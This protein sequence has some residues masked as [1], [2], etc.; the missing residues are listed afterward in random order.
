MLSGKC[1]VAFIPSTFLHRTQV[2]CNTKVKG[3][4]FAMC[5]PSPSF[6]KGTSYL[7]SL[8]L[9]CQEVYV[10]RYGSVFKVPI[11][12]PGAAHCHQ[13]G[14][15]QIQVPLHRALEGF[16]LGRQS[17]RQ[18]VQGQMYPPTSLM[19][20]TSRCTAGVYCPGPVL[21]RPSGRCPGMVQ[22]QAGRGPSSIDRR[23]AGGYSEVGGCL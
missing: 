9:V 23:R 7:L 3:I 1:E 10:F 15:S 16:Q 4:K 20:L 14:P 12:A 19:W 13:D 22:T 18:G 5:L 8:N 21:A 11:G 17:S 6:V 2:W